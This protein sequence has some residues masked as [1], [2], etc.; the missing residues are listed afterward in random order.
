MIAIAIAIIMTI[1]F[2]AL[3]AFVL[4]KAYVQ[5]E[6]TKQTKTDEHDPW[7]IVEY[8]HDRP[9]DRPGHGKREEC[10]CP[11]P[12]ICAAPSPSSSRVEDTTCVG[13]V[14][15]NK[16][17]SPATRLI[18]EKMK[19][20]TSTVQQEVCNELKRTVRDIDRALKNNRNVF[21]EKMELQETQL[22][23][24]KLV[25]DTLANEKKRL[26]EEAQIRIF[27]TFEDLWRE[28][29]KGVCTNGGRDLSLNSAWSTFYNLVLSLC[30]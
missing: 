21:F 26:T 28:I 24:C 29:A 30:A 4:Y 6:S 20:I 22:N 25:A 3:L 8:D 13:A 10:V 17:A 9:G 16:N 11:P 7:K 19:K 15:N 23:G 18:L 2:L 5:E 12:P 27:E 1:A 14:F